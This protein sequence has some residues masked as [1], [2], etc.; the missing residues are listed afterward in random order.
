MNYSNLTS[1]AQSCWIYE[2]SFIPSVSAPACSFELVFSY[3]ICCQKLK[4]MDYSQIIT[5]RTRSSALIRSN[6]CPKSIVIFLIKTIYAIFHCRTIFCCFWI[7]SQE[8]PVVQTPLPDFWYYCWVQPYPAVSSSF[9]QCHYQSC[10][11]V[12]LCFYSHLF[13]FWR[14][15]GRFGCLPRDWTQQASILWRIHCFTMPF[16]ILKE[17]FNCKVASLSTDRPGISSYIC[18]DHC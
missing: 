9:P 2:L 18:C 12:L 6:K 15:I 3:C 16:G 7:I 14:Q 1:T 11:T 5:A 4:K 10:F 17:W 13:C 8:L